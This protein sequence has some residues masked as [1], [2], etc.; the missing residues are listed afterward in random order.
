[1]QAD[2]TTVMPFL[3]KALVERHTRTE[4]FR[5]F[6]R[7]DELCERLRRDVRENREWLLGTLEYPLATP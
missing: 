6:D 5:L 1:M 4:P 7:R 2:Y 3:V